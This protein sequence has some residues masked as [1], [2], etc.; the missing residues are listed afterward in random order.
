MTRPVQTSRRPLGRLALPL[1]LA[2]A[3]GVVALARAATPPATGP[4]PAA[5]QEGTPAAGESTLTVTFQGIKT[6]SGAVMAS[7]S[8]SPEAYAGKAPPTAQ[9]TAAVTGAAV[10]VTF[11]GL[12]PGTYALRAFHDLD[13]D[14]RLNTNPFGV[15]TEPYAFSN[16]ARGGFGPAKWE[17]AAFTIRAGENRQTIDID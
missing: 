9:A 4:G 11:A 7:L 10:T 13:G 1:G 3:L 15:P 14:G 16:N 8:S 6:P 2:A 12:A 17:A 5:D